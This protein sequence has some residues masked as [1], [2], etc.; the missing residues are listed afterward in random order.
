MKSGF[1]KKKKKSLSCALSLC[2][3]VFV[4]H[5]CVWALHLVSVAEACGVFNLTFPRISK[6]Q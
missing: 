4:L 2:M 6:D 3:C 5:V 1:K